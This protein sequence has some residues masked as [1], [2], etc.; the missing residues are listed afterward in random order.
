[1]IERSRAVKGKVRNKSLCS[2]L[3]ETSAD[4]AP[5]LESLMMR[6][7]KGF[8]LIELL[9][10]IAIIGI[11]AALL[12]PALSNARKTA[13]RA[14]C[15]SNERQF[16]QAWTMFANDHN[17][18]VG[19]GT[20]TGGGWLWDMDIAT[21]DDMVAHYGL[22]RT[23]SYCPS[24][25]HQNQDYW[26]TCTACGGDTAV[27]GYWLVIQRVDANFQPTTSPPWNG[28]T[29]LQYASDPKYHF[30]YDLVN[31][32]DPS[33]P[34]QVLLADALIKDGSGSW[35]HVVGGSPSGT[36][37]DS[38]HLGANGQPMGANVCFT[39]GHVEW[40]NMD[41]IRVRYAPTSG[42][43]PQHLW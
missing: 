41:Q 13:Y 4:C 31:S 6:T 33:R 40:K 12:L 21:R 37:H 20:P 14:T 23:A 32:S 43:Y 29:M 24:E 2:R 27:C 22:T 1:M 30:V 16:S 35:T 26:W 7:K 18:K 15:A 39:D 36:Y 25:P 42:G 10:V 5:V 38:A 34:L 19:I 17:G 11:L 8:T 9:V 28:T 3:G